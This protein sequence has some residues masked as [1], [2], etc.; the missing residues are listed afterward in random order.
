MC[1]FGHENKNYASL[2]RQPEYKNKKMAKNRAE[3]K[4][5]CA[6]VLLTLVSHCKAFDLAIFYIKFGLVQ[7][8]MLFASPSVI[9]S[10]AHL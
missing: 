2:P 1:I 9:F 10:C 3:S 4:I 7:I 6:N 8:G 5:S